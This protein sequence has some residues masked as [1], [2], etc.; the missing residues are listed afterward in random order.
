MERATGQLTVK[1]RD[2]SGS[3]FS[4]LPRPPRLNPSP[5]PKHPPPSHRAALGQEPP[6]GRAAGTLTRPPPPGSG[7]ATL[8]LH[9]APTAA[10]LERDWAR[11]GSA[12]ALNP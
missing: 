11:A 5:S 3:P 9:R 4:P 10:G 6:A 8:P 7:S 1:E 12:Q 2:G